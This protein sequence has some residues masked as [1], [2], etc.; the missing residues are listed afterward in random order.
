MENGATRK[1]SVVA[2]TIWNQHESPGH[3]GRATAVGQVSLRG[4]GV[5]SIWK[6]NGKND[7]VDRINT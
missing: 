1:R 7:Q 3:G 5:N 4:D 6:L 2:F